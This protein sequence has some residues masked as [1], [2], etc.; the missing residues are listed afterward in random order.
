MASRIPTVGFVIDDLGHGGA[1]KQLVLL[2]SA[3]APRVAVRVYVL[4]SIDEPHGR[5]LRARGI[6]VTTLARRSGLDVARLRDLTRALK[7]DRVDVVHGFL[8]AADVYAFVAGRRLGRPTILS[9]RSQRLRLGGVR[10]RALRWMLRRAPAVT[11]NSEAGRA[12]LVDRLRVPAERVHRIPNIVVAPAST[13]T[14]DVSRVGCVGRLV[15]LKRFDAVLRALPLVR[16]AVPAARL[17]IVGDG[18]ELGALRV[19]ARELRVDDAVDFAGAL[20]DATPRIAHFSCL[21]VASE[22]EGLSNAA[23]EAMSLGVPVVA[24]PVGDMASIVVDGVTGV[25]VRDVSTASLSTGVV[26]ALTDAALRA[27]ARDE[28]PRRVRERYSADAAL[29]ALLPLYE[30]LGKQTGAAAFEATTPV[31]GE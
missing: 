20:D 21:V 1:Q 17:E 30:R 18:P 16:A 2:A 25:I 12:L 8:D 29:A 6:P 27:R 3:L 15:A 23:L 14:P 4:S 7:G 22:F 19:L 26:R 13:P 9:L 24:L 11:V 10:G 28:A 31:L 5:T